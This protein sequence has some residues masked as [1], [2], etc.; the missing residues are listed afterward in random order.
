MLKGGKELIIEK[1][2]SNNNNNNPSKSLA[3]IGAK[4]HIE[5]IRSK[6]FSIGGKTPNPLTFDLHRAVTRLSAELYT[7]DVH[8][9]MELIQ[10]T[11]L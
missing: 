10:V 8:F 2:G 5:E 9:L 11:H 1:N 7:K 6:K 3:E 4:E